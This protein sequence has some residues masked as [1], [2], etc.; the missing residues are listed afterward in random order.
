M[1]L[2]VLIIFCFLFGIFDFYVVFGPSLIPEGFYSTPEV[3]RKLSR[4]HK[5]ALF[6]GSF[7]QHPVR[8]PEDSPEALFDVFCADP[9]FATAASRER[10]HKYFP[11]ENRKTTGRKPEENRKLTYA[12]RTPLHPIGKKLLKVAMFHDPCCE[13][14]RAAKR[15]HQGAAGGRAR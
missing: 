10:N 7:F 2:S 3:N 1:A 6:P 12:A 9:A 13:D 8:K 4:K 15:E 14:A 11:E 5:Q